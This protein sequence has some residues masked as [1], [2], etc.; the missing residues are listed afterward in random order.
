EDIVAA[1]GGAMVKTAN[2]AVLCAFDSAAS[3]ARAAVTLRQELNAA[4][5]M[6]HPRPTGGSESDLHAAAESLDVHIVVH[7]GPAVAA[8]IDGRLDYF[9][10]T[11]E[12][13]LDLCAFGTT[14][15]V[16]LSTEVAEDPHVI[17]DLSGAGHT[18]ALF[19]LDNRGTSAVRVL[20]AYERS[21]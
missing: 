16:L 11:V 6:S 4:P 10:Q 18:L 19:I 8:T 13:A 5:R 7:Q 15:E 2:G 17:A 21:A 1:E 20:T 14:N 12:S 3:A 9:G